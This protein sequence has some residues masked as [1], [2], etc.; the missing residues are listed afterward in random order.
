M[1]RTDTRGGREHAPEDV[2]Q[3]R[4]VLNTATR[5]RIFFGGLAGFVVLVLVLA[6]V[7]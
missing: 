3:G 7:A 4:V 5:R 2:R 1:A 6:L